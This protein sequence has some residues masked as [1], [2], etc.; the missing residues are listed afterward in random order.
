M[1][2]WMLLTLSRI[3]RNTCL[4][5]LVFILVMMILTVYRAEPLMDLTASMG[6]SLASDKELIFDLKVEANNWNWWTV[7][8]Q[9]ADLSVFAFSD[10]LNTT[11]GT[12]KKNQVYKVKRRGI[13]NTF[14]I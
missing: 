10:L 13:L 9:D 6:H 2:G 1:F 7:R 11:F 14:F 3:L 4:S 5:L 12:E 8:V